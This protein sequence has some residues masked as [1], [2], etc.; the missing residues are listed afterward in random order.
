[1]RHPKGYAVSFLLGGLALALATPGYVAYA[2]PNLAGYLLHPALFLGQLVPYVV[3]GVLWLPWRTPGAATVALTLSVLLLLAA[4]VL[5]L[6]MLWAPAAR[7]GDMIGL[8]FL[9]ISA[10]TTVAL[11]VGSGVALVILWLRARS[12]RGQRPGQVA[13]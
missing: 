3:C 9:A 1:M 5:Y 12:R 10:T 7:G 4:M 6:P 2:A 13:A 11:L 8:A